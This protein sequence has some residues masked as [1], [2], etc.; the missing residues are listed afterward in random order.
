M[1]SRFNMNGSRSLPARR[2]LSPRFY[3]LT[4]AVV[5]ILMISPLSQQVPAQTKGSPVLD[6]RKGTGFPPP[7][8][9]RSS[10]AP[11]GMHYVGSRVCGGCHVSIAATQR[12]TPMGQASTPTAKSA[13]LSEHPLLSYRDGLYEIRIELRPQCSTSSTDLPDP[14]RSSVSDLQLFRSYLPLRC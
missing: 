8:W 7:G 6:T 9:L 3:L 5:S 2:S 4:G 13:I 1:Q 12:Q 11:S 10:G 14:P